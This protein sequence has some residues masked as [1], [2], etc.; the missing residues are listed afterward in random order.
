MMSIKLLN[1][2]L[3]LNDFHLVGTA[4]F[5]RQRN[6][7][8]NFIKLQ[9]KSSGDVFFINLG[10][11]PLFVNLMN[12]CQPATEIDCYIRERLST[13]VM[14]SVELLDSS[15]GVSLIIR[16]I[17]HKAWTYFDFFSSFDDVFSKLCIDDI[18]NRATPDELSC[19]TSVRLIAMCMA[20]HLSKDNINIARDF[21]RYGVSMSGVAVGMRKMFKQ[22]LDKIENPL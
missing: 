19:I 7:F 6:G 12:N 9:R 13:D 17:E 21:A 20:Y 18:K 15:D 2:F 22:V 5:S 1:K 4:E 10:V 16:E 14:L 8:L 11:H 3:T